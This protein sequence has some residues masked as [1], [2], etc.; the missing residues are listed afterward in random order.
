[1][2]LSA[3]ITV[4]YKERPDKMALWNDFLPSIEETVSPTTRSDIDVPTKRSEANGKIGITL[5]YICLV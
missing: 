4:R 3:N 2:G 1:M 5:K